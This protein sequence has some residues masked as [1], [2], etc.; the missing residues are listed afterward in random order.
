MATTIGKILVNEA[1]PE[2]MRDDTRVLD[3]KGTQALFQEL[4]ERYP[5][6]YIDVLQRTNNIARM[7]ATEY[8]GEASLSLKDFKLPSNV[9]EYRAKVR[10]KLHNISQDRLLTPEQKNEAIIKTVRQSMPVVQKMVEESAAK[11][12]NAFAQSIK[13]GYRGSPV[14]LTQL[15]YGDQLSADHK[16][17]IQPVAGLH[18][19]SEG[20]TLGEYW[21]SSYSARKAFT[22]VQFSTAASG[23]LGKQVAHMSQKLKITGKDCGL[24]NS[25]GT[26]MD[27]DD[28]DIIGHVLQ[29]EVNGLPA[30]HVLRKNDLNAIRG[31]KPL[32]RS[33]STCQQKDGGICQKCAGA[34]EQGRFP[35]LGTYIGI[36]SARILTEPLTQ[37]GLSSKHTGGLVSAEAPKDVEGFDE[38][39]QFLQVPK[40]F[41][42]ASTLS[43]V[44]GKVSLV[45]KA[46]Q[47]GQY[48]RI[49]GETVYAPPGREVQ[50]QVGEV[51]EAGDMVTDGT[52]N[53]AEIARYKGL[54]EGRRYF[55]QKFYEILRD[56]GVATHRRNVDT[57]ARAFFDKVDI[58][59]EG[60]AGFTIGDTVSYSDIQRTY[61]PREG[62]ATVS[63]GRAHG[64]YL[65][66]P[67]L[68]YTIG[69]R[70][71]PKVSKFL[72]QEGIQEILVHKDPVGFEPK[73]MRAMDH[74]GK[75][76]DWKTQLTGFGLKKSLLESAQKGSVSPHKNLSPAVELM[77]PMK[78]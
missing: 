19:Y 58:T 22:D 15:L 26:I 39:N 45:K 49:G 28:P 67:V 55:T 42:G 24:S 8:G 61:K 71:T 74:P 3:K 11:E 78:L 32:V 10:K 29:R 7:V 72:K 6:R 23:F 60:A 9:R 70:I 35:S 27:G 40:N 77:D 50:V 17:R 13:H 2:D 1:L 63:P 12:G 76:R 54:G 47:G 16:G 69:T 33:V 66:S 25:V 48:I 4:A 36:G 14:Q 43:P 31:K 41:R 52:P 73:I 44:D 34:R 56:N 20:T 53:P 68:H 65:E 51:V 59:K 21:A 38:V 18:G 57:I 30:G 64:Q 37:L 5:E 62:H 46:P 75:E